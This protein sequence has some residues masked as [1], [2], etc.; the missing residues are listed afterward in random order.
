MKKKKKK[1][2]VALAVVEVFEG[3]LALFARTNPPR[4]MRLHGK[5]WGG[6][7]DS[8]ASIKPAAGKQKILYILLY[9]SSII[10]IRLLGQHIF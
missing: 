8:K 9:Y 4:G 7:P 5:R 3:L 2:V 6:V 1:V 10:W